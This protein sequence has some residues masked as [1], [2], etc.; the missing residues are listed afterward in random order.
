MNVR[1]LIIAV[2]VLLAGCT[3]AHKPAPAPVQVSPATWHQVDQDIVTASKAA[4]VPAR[5]YANQTMDSWMDS[6]YQR[7]ESDFIPWFTGYWTQQWLT[8][9]VTW[10]KVSA[11]KDAQ[12]PA[13]RLDGYLQVQY[14]ERVLEPVSEKIDPEA[15]MAQATAYYIQL[16]VNSCHPLR[17]A[18][19][20]RLTNSTL[21]L[22]AYPRFPSHHPR[23]AA[24]RSINWS[25]PNRWRKCQPMPP[26]SSRSARRPTDPMPVDPMQGSHRLRF[27]PAK[28]SKPASPLVVQPVSLPPQS[29]ASPV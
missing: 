11:Q 16:W 17:N 9:K 29:G 15:V 13:Q 3:S 10:Y 24:L 4:T 2:L 7:T 6:V 18:T 20:F 8:L 12:T 23:P 22:T 19:A 1:A 27:A 14:R 21:T 5:Q 25:M 26:L 28:N